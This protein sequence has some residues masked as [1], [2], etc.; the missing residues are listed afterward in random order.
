MLYAPDGVR[1]RVGRR[2]DAS[3]TSGGER[4]S[5]WLGARG[6]GTSSSG[7]VPS[8]LGSAPPVVR[9]PLRAQLCGQQVARL[10]R[11]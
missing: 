5:M 7:V 1:Q 4:G 8:G 11:S 2:A 3:S 9:L 10:L 6:W